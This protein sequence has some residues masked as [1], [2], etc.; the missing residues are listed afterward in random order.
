MNLTLIF[1]DHL[2][3]K[4]FKKLAKNRG[5]KSIPKLIT[6]QVTREEFNLI[7]EEGIPFK[8]AQFFIFL[9]EDEVKVKH[10]ENKTVED[11]YSIGRLKSGEYISYLG[12][13]VKRK[14]GAWAPKFELDSAQ[15]LAFCEKYGAER[16]LLPE[17][18]D[19]I[20]LK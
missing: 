9:T 4:S 5:L 7:V 19:E 18:K 17:E 11:I 13:V 2:K 20:L 6:T 1:K 15:Y 10:E 16:I 3:S 14:G 12:E 8:N